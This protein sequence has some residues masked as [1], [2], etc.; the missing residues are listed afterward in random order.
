MFLCYLLL[1][2]RGRCYNNWK[3]L[4]CHIQRRSHNSESFSVECLL[5]IYEHYCRRTR[6]PRTV[7]NRQIFLSEVTRSLSRFLYTWV[8]LSVAVSFSLKKGHNMRS[9]SEFV[10]REGKCSRNYSLMCELPTRFWCRFEI[11][12]IVSKFW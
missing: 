3:E 8:K 6:R 11:L 12:K 4:C 7:C 2:R 5:M 9:V 1:S 10:R